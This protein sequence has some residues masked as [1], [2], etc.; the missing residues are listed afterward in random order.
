VVLVAG[1]AACDALAEESGT[2]AEMG[3]GECDAATSVFFFIHFLPDV[4]RRSAWTGLG[5]N[6]GSENSP[7]VSERT[8]MVCGW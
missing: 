8:E 2:A 4:G 7:D 1:G 3:A 5:T 6:R